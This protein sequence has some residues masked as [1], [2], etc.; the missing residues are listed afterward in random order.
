MWGAMG[1]A[2]SSSDREP[3]PGRV[4]RTVDRLYWRI[5]FED[6]V[7]SQPYLKML[8]QIHEYLLPRTYGEVGVSRG[9]SLTLALPGTV[10]VGID[11][12]PDIQFPLLPTATVRTLTSD[13]FFEQV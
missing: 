9:T 4:E 6:I 8:D 11:P 10:C 2:K 1:I 13:A 5:S 3:P 7:W 12:D